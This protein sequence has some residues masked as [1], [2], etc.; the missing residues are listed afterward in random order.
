MKIQTL[1]L[2]SALLLFSAFVQDGEGFCST[3]SYPRKTARTRTGIEGLYPWNTENEG[4]SLN[5]LP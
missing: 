2:I 1:L 5:L 4:T 3:L